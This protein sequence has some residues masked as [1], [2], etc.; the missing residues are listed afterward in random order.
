MAVIG[1]EGVNTSKDLGSSRQGGT[2]TPGPGQ[3]NIGRSLGFGPQELVASTWG[4]ANRG[5][6]LA[7]K[8]EGAVPGPGA[9]NNDKQRVMFRSQSVV[10]APRSATS[11]TKRQKAAP[12]IEPGPGHYDVLNS[13][14]KSLY[15]GFKGAKIAGRP[16]ERAKDHTPGPGSYAY[17][18]LTH[19]DGSPGGAF[20]KEA[21]FTNVIEKSPDPGSYN[22]T[23]SISTGRGVKLHAKL[24]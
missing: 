13:L 19:R 8:N 11:R 5:A 7:S 14:N 20:T 1:T 23:R 24:S 17:H 6:F 18:S 3:Y 22:V 15:N 9:Y 12:A 16:K 4:T 10:I 21:R 2:I